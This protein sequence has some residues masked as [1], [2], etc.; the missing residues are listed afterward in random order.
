MSS[1]Y[2]TKVING[3][4]ELYEKGVPRKKSH[5]LVFKLLRLCG[6]QV[7]LPAYSEPRTVFIYCSAYFTVLVAVL[8]GY[9][10]WKSNGL[11]VFTVIFTAVVL[12]LLAGWYMKWLTAFNQKKHQLT[13]WDEL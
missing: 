13:P 4:Y 5:T 8:Y 3:T 1:D 2:K 12:G 7:R 6:F 10:Q 11:N 9:L